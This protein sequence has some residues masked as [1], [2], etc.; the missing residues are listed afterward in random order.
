MLAPLVP[1]SSAVN[2]HNNRVPE[3]VKSWDA[4]R[5]WM[6]NIRSSGAVTAATCEHRAYAGGPARHAP[7][8]FS[9][10]QGRRSTR[11]GFSEIRP[12]VRLAR[13]HPTLAGQRDGGAR[14]RRNDI[15]EGIEMCGVF[16]STIC[17]DSPRANRERDHWGKPGRIHFAGVT[18]SVDSTFPRW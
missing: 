17:A 11:S 14:R 7:S 4:S 13:P 18:S 5:F 6:A 1:V 16:S 8:I 2:S 3:P 9:W 10:V 12:Q 15:G